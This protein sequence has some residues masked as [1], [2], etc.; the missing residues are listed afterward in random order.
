MESDRQT[1]AL[2]ELSGVMGGGPRVRQRAYEQMCGVTCGQ[3]A[4]C[5]RACALDDAPP[6]YLSLG[7]V[8][9]GVVQVEAGDQAPVD[10]A[11][12][13]RVGIALA[14]GQ[15]LLN[16][17]HQPE[18][19]RA[20]S[21]RVGRDGKGANYVNDDHNALGLLG[22]A[23]IDTTKRG[24]IEHRASFFLKNLPLRGQGMKRWEIGA[25]FPSFH[26]LPAK[27]ITGRSAPFAAC[28]CNL[29]RPPSIR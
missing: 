27:N 7:H 8:V 25:D 3:R 14:Q 10:L 23:T 1:T 2:T 16:C 21:E 17:A 22:L 28:R 13:Q 19:C 6:A 20:S 12:Q 26:T 18:S 15:S 9:R 5:A 11:G 24:G 29:Y 4:L